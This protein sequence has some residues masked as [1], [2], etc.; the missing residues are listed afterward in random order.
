[1]VFSV[2]NEE[3]C[4]PEHVLRNS[5]RVLILAISHSCRR[6]STGCES[7]DRVRRK[8]DRFCEAS[9]CRYSDIVFGFVGCKDLWTYR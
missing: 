6:P 7:V 9:D 2:E 4:D 3:E 1:M 8:E 5:I